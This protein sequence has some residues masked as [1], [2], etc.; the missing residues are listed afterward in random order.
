MFVPNR[1]T[2]YEIKIVHRVKNLLIVGAGGLGREVANWAV[3]GLKDN[4]GWTVAGFL[5]DNP[6]AL[7][8]KKAAIPLV[9]SIA[10]F[11]PSS[12]TKIVI[13]IGNPSLRR[14]LH[15]DLWTKGA[16]FANV[17]H[18]TAIVAE[19][20]RLGVGVVLA[21]FSILSANSFIDDG[22]LI[23]YYAVIQHDVQVGKW[24]YVS[25]HG[26][27]GG[28]SVLGQEVLIGTHSVVPPGAHVQNK[29][30]VSAGDVFLSH[31][32]F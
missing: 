21:P 19:G 31:N 26:N 11:V 30:V 28:G 25:S 1:K 10:G 13:A 14:R 32:H 18:P 23:N 6:S 4:P 9:G 27:V 16:Q 15:E 2:I 5:D 8:G 22:V 7:D 3:A 12:D 20:V 24:C 17:I 29:C